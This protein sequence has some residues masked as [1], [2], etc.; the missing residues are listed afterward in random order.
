MAANLGV[1]CSRKH[2]GARAP[3]L[4]IENVIIVPASMLLLTACARH[5]WTLRK[6]KQDID[7]DRELAARVLERFK[8]L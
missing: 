2:H 1:T 8:G 5:L 6:I 7:R 3:D 4:A